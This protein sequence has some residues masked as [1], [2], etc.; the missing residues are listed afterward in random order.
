MFHGA[1]GSWM[2]QNVLES[3]DDAEFLRRCR[4][5]AEWVSKMPLDKFKPHGVRSILMSV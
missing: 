5:A 1:E 2:L 3:K 4:E